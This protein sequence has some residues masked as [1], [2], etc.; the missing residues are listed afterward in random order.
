M[1]L[2]AWMWS[3][4]KKRAI[5]WRWAVCGRD[6]CIPSAANWRETSGALLHWRTFILHGYSFIYNW[7]QDIDFIILKNVLTHVIYWRKEI[8]LAPM[9]EWSEELDWLLAVSHHFPDLN[10]VWGMWGSYHWLKVRWWFSPGTTVSPTLTA[11][12]SQRSLDMTEKVTIIQILARKYG[13]VGS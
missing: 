9:A 6:G 4:L 5:A 3:W 1:G 11:C 10:P 12:F 2:H 7:I 13:I 8:W